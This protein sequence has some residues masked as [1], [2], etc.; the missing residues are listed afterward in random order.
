MKAAGRSKVIVI[1]SNV[2]EKNFPIRSLVSCTSMSLGFYFSD[3]FISKKHGVVNFTA[4]LKIIV[5]A[6]LA[7]FGKI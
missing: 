4:M 1:F 2:I 7:D 6:A 5:L 3:V